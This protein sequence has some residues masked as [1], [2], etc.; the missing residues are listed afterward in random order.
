MLSLYNCFLLLPVTQFPPVRARALRAR[1]IRRHL[2]HGHVHAYIQQTLELGFTSHEPDLH[3]E[4]VVQALLA[5]VQ[6]CNWAS[7]DIDTLP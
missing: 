1:T 4:P 6:V 5:R 3:V 2:L 7:I